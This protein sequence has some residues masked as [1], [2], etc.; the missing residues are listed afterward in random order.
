[1]QAPNES[2]NIILAITLS[3]LFLIIWSLFTSK[4]VVSKNNHENNRIVNTSKTY[5]N[6]S[7]VHQVIRLLPLKQALRETPRVAIQTTKLRGSISLKGGRLDSV[8][9]TTYRKTINKNSP[10]IRLLAPRDTLHPYF[11]D[12]GWIGKL[13]TPTAQTLWKSDGK[14]LGVGRPVTL[15]WKNPQGVIFKKIFS[16]DKN[17][18]I[19]IRQ[20]LENRS[21]STIH[22]A[23][24][25]SIVRG[26]VG[27][28]NKRH[29]FISYEGPI[30]VL[31]GS[32]KELK[33]STLRDK[34]KILPSKGGWIG[35]TDKYWLVGLIPQ[36]NSAIDTT[37]RYIDHNKG[38]YQVDFKDNT[39]ALSAGETRSYTMRVFTGAKEVNLMAGYQ[40]KYNI[41]MFVRS[42]DFGWFYFLTKPLFYML[43]FLSGVV[44]NVG[45]AIL[46]LTVMVKV[47][48]FP[49]TN[50][51]YRSMARMKVLTPRI[52]E[53]KIQHKGDRT[54]LNKAMIELYKKEKVNP[55]SGCLPL[56]VQIPV[57]FCLYK[58]LFITLEMRQAPFFG[59]IKDLSAPDPLG[60][61]TGFGLLHWHIPLS[62]AF[63]NIGIW[64][65]VM[66][67]TMYLQQRMNPAPSDPIQA[68][69]F[70]LLPIIFTFLLGRFPSGL[71][72]YWAWNNT[73]TIIQQYIIKKRIEKTQ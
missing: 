14:V 67:V 60:I 51:S 49:L 53:L 22:V 30:G 46:I 66:G 18:M 68:K 13:V 50:K 40:K 24:Y 43:D 55:M 57:F 4:T 31:G 73:L 71:V 65:I 25:G 8:V 58:V 16:I 19:T 11:V 26:N 56:L 45:V 23:N 29:Y 42:I 5:S 1:M 48:M 38:F 10:N 36:Q 47:V 64:P 17:Y 54:A 62:L 9:L 70:G 6:S 63:L 72:I 69:I 61:L 52:E 27:D 59:W 33:Y 34:Q 37:Y 2:R 15:S 35:I 41:P 28:K 39:F 3:I 32:L 7:L 44:G 21:S 12:T 20:I